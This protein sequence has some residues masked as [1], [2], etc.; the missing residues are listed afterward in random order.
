MNFHDIN[1]FLLQL[2]LKLIRYDNTS[3]IFNIL[4]K[5]KLR[6]TEKNHWIFS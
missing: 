3:H 5:Q 1:I 2:Y 6:Y 4:N